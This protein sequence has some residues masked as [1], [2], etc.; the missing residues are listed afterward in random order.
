M[1][2]KVLF[3]IKVL[4]FCIVDEYFDDVRWMFVGFG[5]YRLGELDKGLIKVWLLI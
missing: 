1:F 2:N 5:V 3:W 4:V